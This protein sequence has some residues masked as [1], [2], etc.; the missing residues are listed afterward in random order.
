MWRTAELPPS[1]HFCTVRYQGPARS[2][3]KLKSAPSCGV[4]WFTATT[5]SA[6]KWAL[7]QYSRFAGL[8]G[9]QRE[10]H[11]D[12]WRRGLVVS[13][14]RRMSEVNARRVQLVPGP[15]SGGDTISVRNQPTRSTLASIR[16]RLIE[17]QLRLG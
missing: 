7:N 12:A 9:R 10:T 11:T 2:L 13:G 8:T 17:Y 14:V 3:S 6:A 1:T 5:D 15:S 16:G 4:V